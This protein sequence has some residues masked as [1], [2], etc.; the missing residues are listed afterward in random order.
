MEVKCPKCQ[1]NN[2]SDTVFC[3]KCA[4]PLSESA[5]YSH[6]KTF[7]TPAE[8]LTLGSTFAGRYQIIEELG[9]GGMGKVY[10]VLD[11]DINEKIAL[12]FIK[13]EI[14]LD[15]NT[16]TRFQN[17]LKYA[18]KISHRNV[19][20][21]YDLNREEGNYY[22]TMEY[23]SGGDLKNF[24][25]RAKRLD[26]ATA[27]SIAKQVCEGLSEAHKLGI[28]H[29]DLK[30]NNIMI[31]DIGNARIMDFGIAKSIEGKG[32]TGAGVMIGTPE[33]MSP[34]Q[35][36]GKEV[37]QVSDIYS[38]GVI[39]YEMVT[40]GVPFEGETP[41]SVGVM[42][43]SELPKK[44]KEI[45]PQIPEDLNQVILKCLEKEKDKRYQST[46]ELFS[47]LT[48]I[49]NG[50]PTTER[51]NPKKKSITSKEIT[52][53]FS[54][55]KLFVPTLAAA[56]VIVLVVTV[57]LLLPRK[58][59]TPAP[60][61]ENS[62]LVISFKN[63]TG[64]KSYDY[65]QE[66]IPN[67]LITSLEQ[68]GAHYVVT[69]E[70]V[71]DL[72]DQAGKNETEVIDRDLGFKICRMEGVEYI[73]LGSFIKAGEM[74]ATDIKVLDV[75]T[76]KL[77]KSASS[78][79]EGEGSIIKTQIDELSRKISEGVGT[80]QQTTEESFARIADVTTTSM[81]AYSYYLK[82]KEAQ[83][84]LYWEDANKYFKKAV[85]LDPAFATAYRYLANTYGW[86]GNIKARNET[87]EKAKALSGRTTGKERLY[88]EAQ[89]AG[90]FEGN[91]KKRFDILKQIEEKYPKEKGVH[92]DLG[93][94]YQTRGELDK[95][96]EKYNLV[97]ELD[98]NHGPALN[99]LGYTYAEKMEFDKAIYSFTRYATAYPEDANPLDSLGEV[100]YR[101]GRLDEAIAKYREAVK[102]KTDFYYSYIRIGYIYALREDYS[103]ALKWIEQG[104]RVAQSPGRIMDSHLSK[105][106][107]QYW[108]GRYKDSHIEFQKAGEIADT[109][110]NTG[111]KIFV[112]SLRGWMY[113]ETEQ[114][115][116][117]RKYYKN[118]LDLRIGNSPNINEAPYKVFLGLIDL[119]EG[120]LESSKS[121]LEEAK[122]LQP[123]LELNPN[124]RGRFNYCLLYGEVALKENQPEKT[125]DVFN[126]LDLS[127]SYY[128]VD[129][130]G[131]IS[132]NIP[133]F[134]RDIL[135]RA[136]QM[137][138][139]TE[140]A[141]EKYMQL[142]TFDSESTFRYLI[143]PTYHYR[144]AKLY[145]QREWTGKAI[146]HYEKFLNLWK[147][148][149]PGIAEVEDARTR[150]AALKYY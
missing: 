78:R 19:C 120:A 32:I 100:Y 23:V 107:Y 113:Y 24:I 14:S 26:T 114:F 95:A 60:K 45:N 104:S 76:K 84:K 109:L 12:K 138:G 71:Y 116:L 147:D 135:A 48:R 40:G 55:K 30:S 111:R 129:P 70:R 124:G 134:K 52:V 21:M 102:L 118:W 77:L 128:P 67:L 69:W 98:P 132:Y 115:D 80:P 5:E 146:E 58:E 44:P 64:D 61:I 6:T 47:E 37:D 103:E 43:K 13:P 112:E 9:I 51:V 125:I 53:S 57:F 123:K 110:G 144:L 130:V 1:H 59:L 127:T 140:K 65:L 27:I 68:S 2:P 8:K 131:F 92:F 3:G 101:M 142:C 89:I 143:H 148:A 126:K 29:R 49:E 97:L 119:K 87:Y 81:E 94:Y 136:Y 145:E 18:R 28:V 62:I 122:S 74:F 39:L 33:Y 90:F 15:K 63:Q 36:E 106:F 105:G 16:I 34:E 133:F 72:L 88:L 17:E 11:T 50:I 46:G 20:R 25:R 93:Y 22:I 108:L 7:E 54:L 91:P 85:E 35:V 31:D 117:S 56:A 75:E 150:L 79:G 137:N 99:Q 141:I 73:V 139:E 96:T 38:L 83:G 41:F 66:A 4:T 10:K 121:K 86:L 82:G 149:D 42:Q